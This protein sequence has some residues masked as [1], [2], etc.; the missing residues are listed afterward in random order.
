M[1]VTATDTTSE[2]LDWREAKSRLI[3]AM[4]IG[5]ALEWYDMYLYAQ[6]SALIF[7]SLFFPQVSPVVGLVA[8]FATFG[9]GYA[10]RPLGAIV[11]GHIG[12]RYGRRLALVSTLI[13]MGVATALVGCLPSYATIGIAAPILLVL[14]RLLQGLA[15]GAEYAGSL[16]MLAEAAPRSRR[17][18]FTSL[19]GIG[20]YV[21]IILSSAVGALTF[22]AAD[23][24]QTWTWRIPFLVSIALVVVGIFLRL[25]IG[26]SPVFADLEA[27]KAQR[28]LPVVDVFRSAGTRLFYAVLLTAPVSVTSTI[29]LTYSL[30]F[31]VG[32]GSSRQTVLIAS[33]VGAAVGVVAV[34][35]AGALS[36]R[37]GRRPVYLT[38]AIASAIWPVP[39]FLL[40]LDGHTWAI[41]F[42]HLLVAPTTWSITGAQAAYLTEL[43]PAR[44]RYSGVAL[45]R[46]IC[47][48]VLSAP[49]P[50]I[51]VALTAASGGAPWAVAGLMVLASV[52]AVVALRRLPE[53]R[54]T[55]LL[56]K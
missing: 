15:A 19:P 10:A 11:F 26:E 9:V 43:F 20:I 33:L 17:G 36:D 25:R 42:A 40:L 6:A 45:S 56:A 35:V 41:L 53:T 55:D 21:G 28:R 27:K 52:V 50:I 44:I 14:L 2:T 16:V 12:D 39:F 13:L 7:G 8:S 32:V 46:E 54:G 22:S 18:F 38:L 34:P 48:A 30:S 1:D 51:A 37:Y 31:S 24:A 29:V 4:L 3:P 5:S 23:I 49:L 47:N